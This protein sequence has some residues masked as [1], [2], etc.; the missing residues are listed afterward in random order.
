M[1]RAVPGHGSVVLVVEDEALVRRRALNR[2]PLLTLTKLSAFLRVAMTFGQYS[3]MCICRGPWTAL[4]W[5][6][7]L[8]T[9]GRR[10]V[11]GKT[12][13]APSDLPASGRFLRKPY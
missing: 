3:P 4:G 6:K 10:F 2:S 5:P 12:E 13:I 1:D 9:V 11:S 7:S 8:E